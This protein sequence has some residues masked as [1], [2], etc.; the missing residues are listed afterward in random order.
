M[1]Q[2]LTKPAS[3]PYLSRDLRQRKRLG[4][5]Y[6]PDELAAVLSSWAISRVGRVLDPS[7]GGCSFLSAALIRLRA[8]GADSPEQ[9]IH[10]I[11]VDELGAWTS[12][13]PLLLAGVPP[14]NLRCADFL[15]C[16]APESPRSR[17]SAVI[18]NPPY[19]RAR[20][21]ECGS[22][23]FDTAWS[24]RASLWGHFVLHAINFLEGDG[25][26][27]FVLPGALLHGGYGASVVDE[28]RRRFQTVAVVRL[29][30]QVFPDA[31]EESVVLLA[32]DGRHTG[33]AD[34]QF[35]E[36]ESVAELETLLADHELPIVDGT[37]AGWKLACLDPSVQRVWKKLEC[38]PKVRALGDVSTIRIGVVTGANRFF[39][40][41]VDS[42]HGAPSRPIV[43][44]SRWLAS[45]RW[46]EPDQREKESDGQPA[47]LLVL[48]DRLQALPRALRDEINSAGDDLTR[49][50][51]C[52]RRPL[53]WSIPEPGLP[54]AF[55]PYMGGTAPRLIQNDGGSLCT[56]AIHQ[57]NWHDDNASSSAI[58][59]SWTSLF[60]FAAE[61]RG[62]HYG[63]GI[64][65]LEPAEAR[66]L[67]IIA[68]G[69]VDLDRLDALCRTQGDEQATEFADSAILITALELDPADVI[70]LRVG[71][72]GLA[73]R[74]RR[75]PATAPDQPDR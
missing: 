13:R 66:T 46:T 17:F 44:R 20:D 61:L 2:P 5:Y 14:E 54:D 22:G 57:V 15:S 59:S 8:L 9:L 37:P 43:S 23:A 4:L 65:K 1:T 55:L 32:A 62:R 33:R 45:S 51:H 42:T 18:G 71:A 25:R 68:A 74:R 41:P 56:N 73:A 38:H 49:R 70:A 75:N 60:R 39:V 72:A 58:A 31:E 30:A 63:G 53:W 3:D 40:R 10:G 21:L 69:E 29:N 12:A 48:G 11:D 19:I 27:G 67:P 7:F 52:R 24:G 64:L 6:T 35:A 34:A 47:R 36:V 50:A 16:P 26:L 28:V